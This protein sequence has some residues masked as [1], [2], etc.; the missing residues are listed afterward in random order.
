MEGIYVGIHV[1]VHVIYMYVCKS[2]CLYG[3]L[4]FGVKGFGASA[5]LGLKRL[6]LGSRASQGS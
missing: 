4:R 6:G 2:E 3:Y 1:Y 5:C